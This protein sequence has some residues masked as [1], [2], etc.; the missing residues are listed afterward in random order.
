MKKKSA[1]KA[2]HKSKHVAKRVHPLHRQV[3]MNVSVAVTVL[4][5]GFVVLALMASRY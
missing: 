4:L 1:R 3:P 2:H 5:V